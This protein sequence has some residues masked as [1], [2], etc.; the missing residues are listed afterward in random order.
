ML[1]PFGVDASYSVYNLERV[2]MEDP[3]KHLDG[4]PAI[5]GQRLLDDRAYANKERLWTSESGN[6]RLYCLRGLAPS[7]RAR[8]TWRSVRELAR[9]CSLD[10]GGLT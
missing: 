1:A 7:P 4:I 6:R 9:R 10:C 2:Q 8:A 5:D 3:G